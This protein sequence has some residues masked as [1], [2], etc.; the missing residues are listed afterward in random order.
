M[1]AN[2]GP[3]GAAVVIVASILMLANTVAHHVL[4]SALVALAFVGWIGL[5]HRAGLR[6]R[7]R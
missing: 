5:V 1:L 6:K 2:R 7:K 4:V 3:W